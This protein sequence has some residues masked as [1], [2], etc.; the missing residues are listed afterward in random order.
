MNKYTKLAACLFAGAMAAVSFTACS[1]DDEVTYSEYENPTVNNK[2]KQGNDSTLW[3]AV[4][5]YVNNVV[6]PTYSNLA[7][8]ADKLYAASQNIKKKFD[9]G[10]LTDAD[11]Q[12]ACT[13]FEGARYYWERSEA[14]LYGA[15]SDYEIDPHIDSW[16]L[17]QSQMAD[18]LSNPTMVAGLNSADPIKF[19][20]DNNAK[21]DTALGFHGLEFVLYRNGAPRKAAVFNANEDHESFSKVNVPGKNEIAF[22]VAVAGDL[23][24]HCYWLEVAWLGLKAPQ[25]HRDRITELGVK[26]RALQN[27]GY[28][29]GA[30]LLLASDPGSQ[31]H[32]MVEVTAT[33]LDAG[34]SNISKEVYS[35]KMGQAYRVAIGKPETD[36]E[37]NTD[38]GDYIESPYSKRSFIDYQGNIYSIRNSLYGTMDENGSQNDNSIMTFLEKN[39]YSGAEDLKNKLKAAID[40]LE[41]CKNKG[42]FVDMI[43]NKNDLPT[44]KAAIDAVNA[45]DDQIQDARTWVE[46]VNH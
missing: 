5:Q 27:S 19:V 18:F 17:D 40:A 42:A 1:N 7:A 13:A 15:A 2:W 6:Y 31:Y 32:S 24:D 9:A 43:K 4:N 34:C 3:V 45:L 11:V 14:F 29:Y 44:I 41:T 26:T 39:N 22:L 35:Q 12:A 16:P 36:E 37:G 38:A 10:Q 33:I 8:D 30:N 46:K 28:Y 25:A 23:R 20:S 21:F